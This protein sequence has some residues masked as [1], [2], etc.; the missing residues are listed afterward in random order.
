[1]SIYLSIFI[2]VEQLIN[3]SRDRNK[4]MM[5]GRLIVVC[6]ALPLMFFGFALWRIFSTNVQ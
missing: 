1:M 4:K 2:C 6:L 3:V 5:F